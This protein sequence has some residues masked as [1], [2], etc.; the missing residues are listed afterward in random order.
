MKRSDINHNNA[1]KDNYLLVIPGLENMTLKL[2]S[3]PIPGASVDQK[4]MR[5]SNDYMQAL[6][7][8]DVVEYETANWSFLVD[9]DFK[10]YQTLY[11]LMVGSTQSKPTT[12]EN[13]F[14]GSVLIYSSNQ[15][16]LL[17]KITF[18]GLKISGL[19]EVEL[20]T[21]SETTEYLVCFARFQ[22]TRFYFDS[23]K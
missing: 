9:E 20:I 4:K 3:S 8:S 7:D 15:E 16:T 14:D 17:A 21:V 11:E 6:I 5:G 1:A 12:T 2:Q 19:G 23:I 13:E 10:N 22:Y 18:E